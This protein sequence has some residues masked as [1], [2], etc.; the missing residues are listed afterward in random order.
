MTLRQLMNWARFL[1]FLSVF[2][3]AGGA[4]PY[5]NLR[6]DEEVAL[7]PAWAS[8]NAA[9]NGWEVSVRGCVYEP[10]PRKWTLGLMTQVLGTQLEELTEA[11][12]STLKERARSFMIDH[13]RRK[14]VVVRIADQTFDLGRTASNGQFQ[15]TVSLA[16][17]HFPS[18]VP[19]DAPRLAVV[20]LT[21]VL[22]PR[23]PRVFVGRAFLHGPRGITVISDI[24]DTVKVSNVTNR[25]QLLRA[26]FMEPFRAVPGM[27]T[28][29]GGWREAGADFA[30]ISASPWQLLRPLSDLLET[31]GF[32][33]GPFLLK[34]FRW[35]DRSFLALFQDPEEYKRNA[36][37]PLLER[38]PQRQFILVGD[39]GE[40]D[41]EAF[42]WLARQYPRQVVGIAVRDLTQ[43][44]ADSPRYQAAFRGLPAGICVVFRDP[45]EVRDLVGGLSR[46]DRAPGE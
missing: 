19:T 2:P 16:D 41:P 23:D 11:E 12:W 34:N 8:R 25:A 32:P 38:Y 17:S 28:L 13:Q 26:T 46:A 35:R 43:E 18:L 33:A 14:R 9:D 44:G 10:E 21:L 6:G 30:Y 37:A 45:A 42:G 4:A 20:D 40:R 3:A 5:S 22:R 29:Y 27:A 24:D 36:I 31:N 1:T 39:S 7:F 15:A